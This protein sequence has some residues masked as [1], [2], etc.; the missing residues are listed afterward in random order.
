[1]ESMFNVRVDSA[2]KKKYFWSLAGRSTRAGQTALG[3]F[4]TNSNEDSLDEYYSSLD[5]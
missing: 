4:T 1:M 5:D 2:E 3:T